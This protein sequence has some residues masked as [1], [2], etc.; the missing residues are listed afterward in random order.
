MDTKSIH[1]FYSMALL[2]IST[3]ELLTS[4]LPKLRQGKNSIPDHSED[5]PVIQR[6]LK[7][8]LMDIC[9]GPL[10]GRDVTLVLDAS[11]KENMVLPDFIEALGVPV[12]FFNNEGVNRGV[13]DA[14]KRNRLDVIV[15]VVG[16]ELSW[17]LTS[18]PERWSASS[19]VLVGTT[20]QCD[21]R[22]LLQT[23]L[24]QR[25]PAV[26][27]LCLAKLG[28]QR[29]RLEFRVFTWR[30]LHPRRKLLPLGGWNASAFASWD[31]LFVDRFSS[32]GGVTLGV[33]SDHDDMPFLFNS[34]LTEWEGLGYR[35]LNTL[36]ESYNFTYTLTPWASD[37]QWGNW[38]NNSWTG[39][40]GDLYR[41]VKNLTVNFISLSPRRAQYFDISV[42]YY[43][44]GFSFV[45]AFPPPL[46]R[47]YSLVHP[48]SWTMWVVV[49][50]VAVVVCLAY[51]FLASFRE[52][53]SPSTYLLTIAQALL[54][55]SN[56]SVPAS[57]ILRLFLASWW[58]T[59]YVIVMSYTCNLIAFLT[60]PAHP[61]KLE[62]VQQLANS[63]HRVCM[64]D[65]GSYVPDALATSTHQ[66]LSALGEKMDLVPYNTAMPYYNAL[67][68]LD[69]ALAGT[70]AMVEA[71]SY[72]RD[73]VESAGRGNKMYFLEESIF[74]GTVSFLFSK[75]TPWKYKFDEGIYS[76]LESGFIGKW[77]R[78]IMEMR[79]PRRAKKSEAIVAITINHLQGIF[80]VLA[81][82]W[83]MAL[84]TFLVEKICARVTGTRRDIHD[85]E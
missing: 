39:M 45:L 48:F 40:L 80:L 54:N 67:E 60:I 21:P 74:E 70:H 29:N 14:A 26:A 12:L 73:L 59:A 33:A 10:A 84:V 44:E 20:L 6:L 55:Q 2:T 72:L 19:V 75:S 38:E 83:S 16:P 34:S 53:A 49:G 24:T 13:L 46:P 64:L 79:R 42:P 9:R 66:S 41:E 36:A 27:A 76:L 11:C 32:F 63:H 37:R 28:E 18:P 62:S 22:A 43:K 8:T 1:L 68:C 4:L 65:Y 31:Q 77:Y 17:L 3:G 51:W 78:D 69:L 58:V 30:P 35:L 7:D 50:G 81:F 5:H 71:R 82:G 61:F 85:D 47:W 56:S 57:W 15:S 52:K 25:T 23:A